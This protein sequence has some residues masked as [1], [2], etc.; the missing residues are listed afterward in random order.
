MKILRIKSWREKRY[1][2]T[3]K[4]RDKGSVISCEIFPEDSRR[5]GILAVD[6]EK[7]EIIRYTLPEGFEGC[8][9]H[10]HHAKNELIKLF[11]AGDAPMEKVLMWY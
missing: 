8:T 6:A 10:V 7:E 2:K 9:S 1:G 3:K 4:H 5:S 11:K